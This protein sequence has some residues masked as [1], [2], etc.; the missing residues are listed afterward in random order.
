MT[1]E[2]KAMLS[3]TRGRLLREEFIKRIANVWGL[4]VIH[5]VT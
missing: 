1:R 3:P 5:D 2:Q 4:A